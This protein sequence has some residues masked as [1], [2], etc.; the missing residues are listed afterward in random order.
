MTPS[1]GF[2]CEPVDWLVV[3]TGAGI[4]SHEWI[5]MSG[6]EKEGYIR[7]ARRDMA[8]FCQQ[9]TYML[10]EFTVNLRTAKIT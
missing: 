2:I 5:H 10:G 4:Y 8:R 1:R 9:V 7:Q 3:G 6:R